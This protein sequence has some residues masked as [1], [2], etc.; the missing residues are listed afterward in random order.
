MFFRCFIFVN[1]LI[2][3]FGCGAQVDTIHNDRAKY[4]SKTSDSITKKI[5]IK[6]I[7]AKLPGYPDEGICV[8]ITD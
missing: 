7:Q 1:V 5:A 2:A 3:L 8:G 6:A 4:C